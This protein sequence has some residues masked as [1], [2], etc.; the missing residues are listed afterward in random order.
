[1]KNVK[2]RTL[3]AAVATAFMVS[4][5]PLAL[6]ATPET[7]TLDVG[8]SEVNWQGR[9]AASSA[10]A[11]TGITGVDCDYFTLS[12]DPGL[13]GLNGDVYVTIEMDSVGSLK[14]G[15]D[16]DM[17]VYDADGNQ[18]GSSANGGSK[19]TVLL[20]NPAAGDYT[21]EHQA[22]AVA[23]L[24]DDPQYEAS[25]RYEIVQAGEGPPLA[26]V[27][28]MGDSIFATPTL[29]DSQLHTGEPSIAVS[30]VIPENGSR[31]LII[32]DAPWGTSNATSLWWR[33]RD[34]GE[35]FELVQDP[36]A[37]PRPRPCE[38]IDGGGDSDTA[39]DK[40]GDIYVNDLAAL[41]NITVGDSQDDFQ[42]MTCTKAGG[43]NPLQPIQDRQWV[44]ASPLADGAGPNVDAYITFRSGLTGPEPA[45][46]SIQVYY[47]T[48]ERDP[49]TGALVYESADDGIVDPDFFGYDNT[50]VSQTG[51]PVVASDGT[52]WQ[53]YYFGTTAKVAHFDPITRDFDIFEV[54]TRPADVGNVFPT[55]AIDSD[56]NLYYAW[57]EGGS[58]DVLLA[59]S[60]DN[61]ETW[62]EPVRINAPG[63][64]ELAVNP[65][66]V[67]GDK[68]R[69]AVLFNA[70]EGETSPDGAD[71]KA[72]NLYLSQSTNAHRDNREFTQFKVTDTPLHF[73]S[74]CTGGLGCTLSGGD[75][76][77]LEFNEVD[78]DPLD[79]S[80]VFIF[81]DNGRH[82]QPPLTEGDIPQPYIMSTRQIAGVSMHSGKSIMNTLPR[83]NFALDREGDSTYPK[84][85][86]AEG[87]EHPVMDI[88]FSRLE[89]T[90]TGVRAY[91]TMND[92][93][94][95]ASAL[96]VRFGDGDPRTTDKA[97]WVTRFEVNEKVFALGM[98]IDKTIL[99]PG[100]EPTFWYGTP[101]VARSS[102]I[103]R[104]SYGRQG[105]H[106]ADADVGFIDG[107]TIVVEIPYSEM[108]VD[109]SA[110]EK[111]VFHSVVT[112]ALVQP[113][114]SLDVGIDLED[115]S[116]FNNQRTVDASKAYD[117]TLGDEPTL[118]PNEDENSDDDDFDD[119]SSRDDTDSDDDNDG[120]SDDSDSDDDNDGRSDDSDSDDDNDGISD[121]H[122]SE[123]KK[124]KK[125]SK[126]TRTKG[127]T[128]SSHAMEVDAN[129][130]LM[131][132]VAEGVG[133][134]NLKLEIYNPAGLLVATSVATPGKT[135]ATAVPVGG[136][137]Y[138]VKVTNPTDAQVDYELKLISRSNWL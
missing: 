78:I 54:A 60:T 116:Y 46:T 41:I 134:E 4:V 50:K 122:D 16:W 106:T 30:P 12:I 104:S 126:H 59:A 67:A 77:L 69:V 15:D 76:S 86:T 88:L 66:M 24:A 9:T 110:A 138:S 21:V 31:P 113:D 68:G 120:K 79:G 103:K 28:H 114:G 58:F 70:T 44:V 135:L 117:W 98:D 56:D 112:F 25:A 91:M 23:S 82:L 72:W 55:L 13:A 36:Y 63:D 131:I 87:P 111:P 65:Y 105:T 64:S 42:T 81:A 29:M 1:M 137:I 89:A 73:N 99:V 6:T 100:T 84:A 27:P 43:T 57:I 5:T 109:P 37:A 8:A 125:K 39:I 49:A 102:G 11:C 20:L 133:A 61:G 118:P 92:L 71:G 129:T 53:S 40:N 48:G 93:G 32:G 74:I 90:D 17:A 26:V 119:D 83:T 80:M 34:G 132:A 52:L 19:E 85:G 130:L 2:I 124:E 96:D 108:G 7:G 3:R 94:N 35:S 101:G 136:G 107:D 115:N 75:R 51:N 45:G 121:D 14:D 128:T 47:T 95:L 97:M 18:L 33:S 123:S 127:N 10:G 62:S 22:F 38:E